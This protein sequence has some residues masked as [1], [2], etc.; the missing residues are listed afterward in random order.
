MLKFLIPISL[1]TVSLACGPRGGIYAADPDL[2]RD[3]GFA[4]HVQAD[5]LVRD[6]AELDRNSV[7][8]SLADTNSADINL[9]DAHLS[10]T[11]L[12]DQASP[13]HQVVLGDLS[14][15]SSQRSYQV[16]GHTRN[17]QLRVPV[18]VQS[19]QCPLILVLHGNGDTASNF[20]LTSGLA[21]A[22]NSRGMIIAAPDG[23]EQNIN[24]AGQQINGVDWDGYRS[25]AEG[26][27]DLPL[28]SAILSDLIS[29]GSVDNRRIYVFGYS[30]GGYM[31]FRVSID[32]SEIYAAGVVVAGA[33][34]LGSA[35]VSQATRKIP[36]A[37]TIGSQDYGVAN[38][39]ECRDA[40]IAAGHEV[41]WNEVAGAGHVPYC[42]DTGALLDWLLGRQL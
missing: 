12:P 13:D 30:Q 8:S 31:S 7:D 27:I 39:R 33:S 40:L 4:D 41:R 14:P 36:M 23:I 1:L 10:D 37:L 21:T 35:L 5:R 29:S 32:E 19:G 25:V 38:A 6:A 18:E 28:F 11:N 17:V 16:A 22:A 9:P 2:R 3:S 42:G 15:G 34:P 20:L 26:N 24:F